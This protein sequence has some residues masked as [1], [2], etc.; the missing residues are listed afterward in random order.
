MRY[1]TELQEK[2]KKSNSAW[3]AENATVLGQVEL[4]S[5]VTVWYNAVIRAESEP[6][7]IGEGSNIQDNCTIH[8]DPNY[9][10]SIGKYVTVGHGAIIHGATI[11]DGALI[12]IGAIVLNG[13][14]IGE[15]SLIG[16]GALVT[17]GTNIPPHSL[18]MGS[19]ARVV[20]TLSE[21]HRNR[22]K[23]GALHYIHEGEKYLRGEHNS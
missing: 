23:Q 9:P 21:E 16:A 11:Q 6:V 3:V 1:L 22:M 8:V 13:A 12:G 17:E 10:C 18:V 19:P 20:K 7:N 5:K 2:V 4:S 15:G 14:I